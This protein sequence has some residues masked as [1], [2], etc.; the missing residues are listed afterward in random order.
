[1]EV[2]EAKIIK[3]QVVVEK[4]RMKGARIQ[5]VR[6]QRDTIAKARETAQR[7]RDKAAKAQLKANRSQYD[8]KVDTE[9]KQRLA[10]LARVGCLHFLHVF[11]CVHSL[12]TTG[13]SIVPI[14][15]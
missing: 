4:Q 3:S 2:K 6:Q 7:K 12:T 15:P 8:S 11:R 5:Q 10:T 9:R 14:V 1:M 13:L